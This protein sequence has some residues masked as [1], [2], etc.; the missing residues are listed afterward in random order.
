MNVCT[1]LR[2]LLLRGKEIEVDKNRGG[3]K[4]FIRWKDLF[5]I[6]DVQG[7]EGAKAWNRKERPQ[8]S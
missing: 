3:I 1:D 5:L 4:V 6:D 2:S 8:D 7:E